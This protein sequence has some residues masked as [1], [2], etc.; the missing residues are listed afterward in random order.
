[1]IPLA[2][3]LRIVSDLSISDFK[4]DDWNSFTETSV[5]LMRWQWVAAMEESGVLGKKS[6][7]RPAHIAIY[8]GKKPIAI[9]PFYWKSGVEAEWSAAGFL[10]QLAKRRE[11]PPYKRFI[12]LIPFTPVPGYHF[13]LHPKEDAKLLNQWLLQ[14]L[15]DLISGSDS[16]VQLQHV[17]L[18][19]KPFIKALKEKKWLQE[20]SFTYRWFNRNY[21]TFDDFLKTYSSK[22]RNKMKREI[23]T[24]EKEGISFESLKDEQ[25]TKEVMKQVYDCYQAN[26]KKHYGGQGALEWPF[27]EFLQKYFRDYLLIVVAKKKDKILGMNLFVED[28]KGLYGRWWGALEEI[29]FLHF[30]TCYY[31]PIR[32]AIEKKI[33]FIDPGYQGK[34]KRWR[35][36]ERFQDVSFHYCEN[37]QLRDFLRTVFPLLANREED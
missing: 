6:G 13:L 32:Y 7:F 29:P 20:R 10:M 8:R 33:S 18:E 34:F 17:D 28:E 14:H 24:C 5:S 9:A 3:N 16:L 21:K 37:K 12:G 1:V 30:N 36:F 19:Q 25:I 2:Q 35:G 27:W 22:R 15:E 31:F 11:E 26:H 23:T 4:S